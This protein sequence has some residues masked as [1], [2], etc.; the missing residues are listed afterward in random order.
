MQWLR[1]YHEARNDAK[2]RSLTDAQFRV[3][4]NLLCYASE[5]SKRGTIEEVDV[6]VLALEVAGGDIELLDETVKRLETFHCVSSV[7]STVS[8]R[9]IAFLNFEKRQGRSVSCNTKSSTD[10]VRKHREAKRLR[11]RETVTPSGTRVKRVSCV[12]P[13]SETQNETDETHRAFH[14]TPLRL[15]KSREENNYTHT[16][17]AHT[18]E[19][20][21]QPHREAADLALVHEAQ[22][23]LGSDLRTETVGIELGREHN[24]PGMI[25]IP[26]WKW[27]AAAHT[28][29]GPGIK[30]S[31]RRSF[32][33]FATVAGNISDSDRD[34]GTNGTS[35][36]TNKGAEKRRRENEAIDRAAA[37]LMEGH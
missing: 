34:A 3:W 6:N 15:D 30:D 23:L 33:Y 25:E 20:P 12:S 8:S 32:S 11:R 1:L 10:R 24:I 18:C 22:A 7:S 29:L 31:K 9:S 4:F 27:L 26:G 2:L 13:Q 21:S 17:R 28:L 37:E 35:P 16:A 14:E 5:Q 19:A 36:P